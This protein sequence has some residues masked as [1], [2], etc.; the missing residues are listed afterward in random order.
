MLFGTYGSIIASCIGSLLPDL[1]NPH[2]L[3]GRRVPLL[4]IIG[5]GHRAWM[6]S[7]FGT[8]MFSLI[9][10]FIDKS[11]AYALAI[12]CLTHLFLDMLNPAGVKLFWPFGRRM[13]LLDLQSRSLIANIFVSACVLI[14]TAIIKLKGSNIIYM[15]NKLM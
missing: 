11:T 2:S 14:I 15:I 13:H 1:D 5:G 12:G 6:H 9:A 3:L 10:Y 8:A 7:L 4:S